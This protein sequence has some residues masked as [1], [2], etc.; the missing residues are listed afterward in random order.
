MEVYRQGEEKKEMRDDF[1][2]EKDDGEG[3]DGARARGQEREREKESEREREREQQKRTS[4]VKSIGESLDRAI[5]LIV[6]SVW[7]G[8]SSEVSG[9]EGKGTKKKEK[10]SRRVSTRGRLLLTHWF[11]SS[12]FKSSSD[13]K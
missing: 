5:G 11:R 4:L 8:V 3:R 9:R 6:M 1:M 2:V 7:W 13:S 10:V 12:S